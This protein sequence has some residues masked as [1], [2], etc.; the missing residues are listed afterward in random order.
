MGASN[1][2]FTTYTKEIRFKIIQEQKD[3]R[4][5]DTFWVQAQVDLNQKHLK[6]SN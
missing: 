6:G 1:S 2:F 3:A 4:V 5:F